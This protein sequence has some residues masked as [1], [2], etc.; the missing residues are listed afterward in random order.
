LPPA[1]LQKRF[2]AGDP[3]ASLRASRAPALQGRKHLR[4]LRII[5]G[6]WRAP[7]FYLTVC[8]RQRRQVLAKSSVCE[9]LVGAW[10]NSLEVYGW[11]VGRYVVMPDHVHFFASPATREEKDLS[12]FIGGWK[13]WTQEAIHRSG[14]PY[15]AWQKEFFDHL[16]RSSES[17]SE[18]WEYVRLNPV[19]AQLVSEPEDWPY[20]GEIHPLMW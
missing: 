11:R 14:L 10:Q 3:S 12:S 18:K 7:L 8:V 9:I 19:R 13:N 2:S 20:Q 16:L 15:F 1:R 4:R 6:Q 5:F 17:Y